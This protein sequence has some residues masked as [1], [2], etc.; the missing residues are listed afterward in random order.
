MEL[1]ELTTENIDNYI[2]DCVALQKYL[3]SEGSDINPNQ[4]RAT[5]ADTNS[6]LLGL[7]EDGQLAGMG[8]ISKIVHPVATNGYVNNIVVSPD[9]RGKGYFSVLM[10]ELETVARRWQCG[11]VDLTCSREGVQG[12]YEKRGYTNKETNFYILKLT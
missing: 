5:A 10:D 11:R 1:K 7:F 9:F 2:D 4:F 12:M 3:V 8:V 6:C